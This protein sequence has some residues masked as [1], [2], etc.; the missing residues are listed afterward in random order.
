MKQ[1]LFRHADGVWPNTAALAFTVL[2]WPLGIALLGQS[3]WALNALGVLLVALTLTWSAYFI[4][5]FA[6]HAIFRTPQANERWGQFMSWI[7][8]SAY[9]SFADLRRKHMRHHVERADVITFDLQGFLRA[10]P[11][12]RRVVL[13]LE[14]L[15]IP[16]VEFVM[17]GFVIALPF[18]GDRKK[19]ARGRVI[20]VAVV[21]LSAW[22]LLA[23]WS[24]KAL[25]LYAL[26]Y[27][28]FVHLLRFADCFQHTYDAYPILDDKPIPQ[29]KLRDRAYEQANTFS[30]V[31]GLD[32]PLLNLVWLNFGFH[33]A[34]H[35]RPVAPWYQL[36]RLHREL[37]PEG[38]AQVVTVGEL[39]R[40]YHRHR[41]TRVLASDYGAVLPPGAPHRAD[42][43][44]GAV[45][46]SFLTAV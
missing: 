19:A 46:V 26:A 32:A 42:G 41:V 25:A 16:A 31:V 21:R 39:L 2:G 29:D 27:L 37:Y 6:H 3:H 8:G 20:G 9:A 11:L 17:R 4:H 7:N 12:V 33:D 10:H 38:N 28:L 18:L 43:F 5:E 15:H 34:H 35:E 36:P 14:W 30:D 23:W 22:A 45:G 40:A 1:A 13:A 44:I 24:L